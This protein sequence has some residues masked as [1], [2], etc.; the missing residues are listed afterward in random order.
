[1]LR[2]SFLQLG[3]LSA[4]VGSVSLEAFRTTRAK[5]RSAWE[6]FIS[7]PTFQRPR[8]PETVV[9]E[10]ATA[11]IT[12]LGKSVVR[13]CIRQLDGKRGYTTSQDKGVNLELI[14]QL[15]VP[16]TVHWHGLILP[17]S[18]DGVPFV[19]QPPIPPGQ[20][21]R[22]HYPLVQNGTFWMH[23]HYGLQ[24]Q[25][26]VAEPFVILNEEQERWADR[27]ITVMLRDFSYTPANQILNNV[28]AGERGGGTA[29]AKNLADFAWHQPR[30]LLTQH[31]DQ[32][33]QRFCWK[34][35]QGV[36]MMAPDVVYDALLANERSLDAPEIIDVEPG[37]TVAIR[38]IAGSAFMSF[39]LDLGDLEGE[40]LR[41]DA[42][43][44]EPINGSV[45]QL[46]TAQ[47]LTLRV[48]VPDAPGV[49]PLLALGERSNLRCGVVL[50]SN[51]KLSAPELEPQTDQWTGR[52]DFNQDKQLRAQK[53]L[54]DRAADNTI[55]I[56]LTGPAPKYTWGLN[57]RFYPYRDPYWVEEGQRVEMVFS[58]PTP[59][60]HPM[61]LHGHEFQIVE[62]DGEPLAGAMRDTV[63]VPKGGTCRI[64]FDAN[65]PGIW[66]FHCHISYHH[67]RGMF[68]V[69]AYR[70]ADLSW[71][72][73]TG[74]SHEHLRFET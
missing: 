57:H 18:M 11:P 28:V 52:L 1:M 56:A 33:N 14:N 43:P 21:Q 53:P 25:N 66:A 9:L 42:N 34:R 40:L 65:N 26:Y 72:N 74:F 63:Y 64:A 10:I 69:V 24:T 12:V 36:L 58:N 60:G 48:K 29:M 71:W 59:M 47:R 44:V 45:F 73:T 38:W 61:H 23:S 55:P 8:N 35:E 46:A 17:N 70:S 15:P 68:N 31:W 50:R 37:E 22:I 5:V 2:R 3:M 41:T 7:Q 27:T 20:R 19:T 51:P 67:V 30:M 32:A 54:T 13:G 16:T 6:R 4:L 49:F 39:F 62:I